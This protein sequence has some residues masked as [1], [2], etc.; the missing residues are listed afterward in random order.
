MNKDPSLWADVVN[1]LKGVWPQIWGVMLAIIIG[2]GRMIYDGMGQKDHWVEP[3]L[4]GFITWAAT[5]GLELLFA[6]CFPHTTVSP[7]A[8]SP[9][10]GGMI[11]LV[12]VKKIRAIVIKKVGGKDEDE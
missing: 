11:G 1:L 6:M 2:Y 9:L 3:L 12:G 5:S 7:M 4:C 8:I 10:V